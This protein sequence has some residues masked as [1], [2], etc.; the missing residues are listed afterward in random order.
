MLS[1][2]F[3]SAKASP[4]KRP[5]QRKKRFGD[6]SSAVGEKLALCLGWCGDPHS[7]S[8]VT[9]HE[10]DDEVVSRCQMRLNV[11]NSHACTAVFGGDDGA[12]I[13]SKVVARG[14]RKS[15]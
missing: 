14:V 2:T 13:S 3:A 12:H 15:V 5:S 9:G 4:R 6:L 11:S 8:K 10:A 1:P 7:P